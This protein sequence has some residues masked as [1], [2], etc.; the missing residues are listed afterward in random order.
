[1]SQEKTT[2]QVATIARKTGIAGPR[3]PDGSCRSLPRLPAAFV[4]RMLGGSDYEVED[5][6]QETFIRLHL[7]ISKEDATASRT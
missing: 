7:Q 6:V 1:M 2:V 4:G 5:I 3:G